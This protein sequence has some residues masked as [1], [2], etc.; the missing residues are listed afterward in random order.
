MTYTNQLSTQ[1]TRLLIAFQLCLQCQQECIEFEFIAHCD[2]ILAKK[3]KVRTQEMFEHE[4]TK[5]LL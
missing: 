1:R 5:Q 4:L 3:T 2:L